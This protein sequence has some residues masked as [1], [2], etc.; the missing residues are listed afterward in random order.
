MA[1]I[2]DMGDRDAAARR[3]WGGELTARERARLARVEALR[4]DT[5]SPFEAPLLRLFPWLVWRA[6]FKGFQLVWLATALIVAGWYALGWLGQVGGLRAVA[7]LPPGE[8]D[9]LQQALQASLPAGVDA[10][11]VWRLRLE[12]A[13]DGEVVSADGVSTWRRADMDAFRSWAALGPDLIGRE[14]LALAQLAEG[15][16]PAPVDARLRAGALWHRTALLDEHYRASLA[17]G[18]AREL[19]PPELVFAP[20]ELVQR[21]Q[22]NL[23]SASV[24]EQGVTDFFR[25]DHR[26]QLELSAFPGV[27]TDRARV[28]RLYGGPRHLV[29]QACSLAPARFAGCASGIVPREAPDRLRLAL[30]VLETGLAD[31][32]GTSD[33]MREG[34]E[35]L[36]AARTAGQLAPGLE[37]QLLG[38]VDRLLPPER[39]LDH[40]AEGNARL[41]FIF[42]APQRARA[43]LVPMA[44]TGEDAVALAEVLRDA[45]RVRDAMRPLLAVRILSAAGS[46]EQLRQL[47][48]LSTLAGIRTLA[49]LEQLGPSALVPVMPAPSVRDWPPVPRGLVLALAAA[50]L[51]L[52]LTLVRLV[53]PSEMRKASRLNTLDAWVSHSLLGRKI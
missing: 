48:G 43:V 47:T 53:T 35:I 2:S 5:V 11:D 18:R 31:L 7:E 36:Q 10:Y 30:A 25:G 17:A 26:G 22:D 16:D 38:L 50:C 12:A 3:F 27:M 49:I 23:F 24:A 13:L 21:Y 6:V 15:G 14:R 32:P 42:A 1:D 52:L 39:V 20:P 34:A 41:D 40:L 33:D 29:I 44:L 4:A 46:A 45:A 19:E 9:R 51:V 37:S 28:G 8:G